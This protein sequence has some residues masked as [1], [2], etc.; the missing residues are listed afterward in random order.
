MHVYKDALIHSHLYSFGKCEQYQLLTS[1]PATLEMRL[2]KTEQ[3]E[4]LVTSAVDMYSC[5]YYSYTYYIFRKK[6]AAG[7]IEL[8]LQDSILYYYVL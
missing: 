1:L 8:H 6:T 2:L 7:A 3:N 5:I 4:D